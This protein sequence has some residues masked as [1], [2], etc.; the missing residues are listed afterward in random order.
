M[1]TVN[2]QSIGPSPAPPP[3]GG[4]L[5]NVYSAAFTKYVPMPGFVRIDIEV[6]GGDAYLQVT[7]W[8]EKDHFE[9]PVGNETLLRE[10]THSIPLVRPA[11]GWR[12]RAASSTTGVTVNVRTIG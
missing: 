6:V 10:G 7:E 1:G 12:V 11:Y 3:A 5:P 8:I 2:G 9:E 4:L